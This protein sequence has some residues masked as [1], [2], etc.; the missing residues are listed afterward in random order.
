MK[1]S[2]ALRELLR[3]GPLTHAQIRDVTGWTFN[4]TRGAICRALVN[5]RIKP[6]QIINIDGQRHYTVAPEFRIEP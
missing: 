6:I 1:R 3:H 5:K 4:Q 2:D